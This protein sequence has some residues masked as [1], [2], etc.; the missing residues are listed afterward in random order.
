MRKYREHLEAVI[1]CVILFGFVIAGSWVE[2]GMRAVC[3][4]DGES[5]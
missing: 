5:E 1:G 4:T 2:N 3:P